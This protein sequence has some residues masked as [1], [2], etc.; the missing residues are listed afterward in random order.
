M[1][2]CL[3]SLAIDKNLILVTFDKGFKK[4]ESKGLELNLLL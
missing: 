1:D 2:A 4:M 3:A